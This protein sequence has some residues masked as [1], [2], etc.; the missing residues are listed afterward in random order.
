[1]GHGLE[2]FLEKPL[3]A[4]AGKA[5]VVEME[6]VAGLEKLPYREGGPFE[7]MTTVKRTCRR[8]RPRS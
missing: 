7:P 1:M 5:E 6:D 8:G 2:A 4:L 3:E